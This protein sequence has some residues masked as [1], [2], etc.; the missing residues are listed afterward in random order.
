[1][2]KRAL[3]SASILLVCLLLSVGVGHEVVS[4]VEIG[5]FEVSRYEDI[6]A[7]R[8]G[9]IAFWLRTRTILMSALLYSGFGALLSTIFTCCVG[10]PITTMLGIGFGEIVYLAITLIQMLPNAYGARAAFDAYMAS[11]VLSSMSTAEI[12]YWQ[13]QWQA[14]APVPQEIAYAFNKAVYGV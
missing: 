7:F 10:F 4:A 12:F 13:N 9:N 3:K 14:G 11:P 8:M 2:E 6:T 5:P 1:M